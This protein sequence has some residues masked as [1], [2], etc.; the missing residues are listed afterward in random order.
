MKRRITSTSDVHFKDVLK[1]C[2]YLFLFLAF[3]IILNY[4]LVQPMEGWLNNH[5]LTYE[6]MY[7]PGKLIDVISIMAH[8]SIMPTFIL[9]G[10]YIVLRYIE[11]SD[12]GLVGLDFHSGWFRNLLHGM[13]IGI[14]LMFIGFIVFMIFGWIEIVD[15]SIRYNGIVTYLYNGFYILISMAS[16]AI[17]E[18][19]CLRGYLFY[20]IRKRVGV[21]TAVITTSLI[22]G[23]LHLTN[24]SAISWSVYVIPFSLT[25]AGIMLATAYLARESLWMAIGLHF[26]WN[27]FEYAVFNLN[28]GARSLLLVTKIQGPSLFVGLPNSSFGPEVGVVGILMMAL[29]ISYFLRLR[30]RNINE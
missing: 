14:I 27:V 29:G 2:L 16:V 5:G 20:L 3:L 30:R 26:S 24:T 4:G 22:F 13:V 6:G 1:V 21:K 7:N 17:F 25:L 10:T 18:E 12:F 15:L 8:K 28:G 23:L 9:I 19:V 11:K